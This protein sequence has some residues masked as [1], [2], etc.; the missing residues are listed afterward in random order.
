MRKLVIANYK[1]IFFIKIFFLLIC[2]LILMHSDIFAEIPEERIISMENIESLEFNAKFGIG[3]INLESGEEDI[4]EGIFQY[5]D[6]ILLKPTVQYNV[7]NSTGILTLSQS[8]NREISSIFSLKNIWD[9]RLP[10][11]IP[12]TISIN[13]ATCNGK[14]NLT[15]MQV[16]KFSLFSGAS[17]TDI[18]FNQMNKVRLSKISIRTGASKLSLYGLANANF[19]EM[20]FNGGA[21]QY[22]FDFSGILQNKSEAKINVGAAKVVLKIPYN[23]GTRI[24]LPRISPISLKIQDFIKINDQVYVNRDYGKTDADLDIEIDGVLLNIEVIPLF[25]V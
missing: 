15:G 22:I 12:M 11:N 9:I 5:E 21:G 1:I 10:K 20:S 24:K 23:Q 8:F 18:F 19:N 3:E 25:D 6:G 14:I 16:Q 13:T 2:N 7:S 4:F 17:N